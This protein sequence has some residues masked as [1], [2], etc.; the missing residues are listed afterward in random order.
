MEQYLRAYIKYQQDSWVR[1][2]PIPEFTGNNHVSET[3][4]I[5]PFF[6]QYGLNAKINFDLDMQ[7]DNPQECP[8]HTLAYHV[9]KIHDIIK[10]EMSF[11]QDGQ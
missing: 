1:F 3:T 5:S 2:L 9:S 8:A 11:A 7:V 10:S 4:G 6:A